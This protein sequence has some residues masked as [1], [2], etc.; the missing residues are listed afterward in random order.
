MIS[1]PS[2]ASAVNSGSTTSSFDDME[3]W[4]GLCW[5]VGERAT[6]LFRLCRTSSSDGE[7][8]SS[9]DPVVLDFVFL[10]LGDTLRLYP[11][12]FFGGRDLTG[13]GILV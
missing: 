4:D 9:L 5:D 8:F 2:E 3:S 7:Y 11:I 6:P 1:D 13:R 12:G 10:L